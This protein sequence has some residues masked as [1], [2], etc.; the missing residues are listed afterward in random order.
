MDLSFVSKPLDHDATW[1]LHPHLSSDHFASVIR[2]H[3]ELPATPP[4][5]PRWNLRKADWAK[6][7]RCIATYLSSSTRPEDLDA[8]E[9]HLTRAFRTAANEAIPISTSTPRQP[10]RDRWYYTAEVREANHRVNMARKLC[11][12][13]N[14][15]ATRGLLRAAIRLAKATASKVKE[16][17]WLAWC[18][19]LDNQTS[20]STLWKKIRAVSRGA[21]ARPALHPHPQEEAERLIQDFASRS[22]TARLFH[23]I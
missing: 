10:H 1:A 18:T 3:V 19:S 12:R 17:H 2:L 11:R 14:T 5:L 22:A 21:V 20:V 6:F 15:E 7:Q 4:H 8:L 23:N 16:E 9:E 13:T